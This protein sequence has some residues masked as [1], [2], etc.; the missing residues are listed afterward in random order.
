[1][2]DGSIYVVM[3]RLVGRSLADKLAR[4]GLLAPG[5]AVPVFIGVCR[6]LAAAHR[7]GVVHR[8][9]KPGNIFLLE[10]GSSKVLD[11]G[12]SKL[13]TAESLTQTGYTLGT[14]EYM[15]PE[16][17]IGA[18]VE[19]RTDIY[20]LGVLMYEAITGELPIIAQNRR[21]L[22]DLHQRQIPTAMRVRRPDLPIPEALDLAVMKCLKKRMNERP[23]SAT[24]LEQL[25]AAVPLDGVPTSYPPGTSRRAPGAKKPATAADPDAHTVPG[26]SSAPPPVTRKAE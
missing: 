24:E 17:C 7:R 5:F 10:D 6:A 9:L 20:A 23:R 16:Q 1:M 21:E 19:P 12:M 4:D 2:P 13:A 3:E 11:F 25:L 18:T 15:A 22:L 14:P 26:L 8:D